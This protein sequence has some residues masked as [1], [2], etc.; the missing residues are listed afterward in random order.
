[1]S[2]FINTNTA[3]ANAAANLST[4]NA[5]L[6]DSLNKLSSGSRIVNAS[7]DAGGLA[8]AM[9]LTSAAL[10]AGASVSSDANQLSFLQAQDG[11][12]QVIGNV[13]TRMSQLSALASDP[14]V[15]TSGYGTEFTQLST[16]LGSL[17]GA[18][19]NG[20]S[21]FGALGNI[22]AVS[23]SFTSGLAIGSAAGITT[24]IG[25]LAS[26]RATNGAQQSSIGYDSQV[27][28]VTQTNLQAAAGQITDVDVATEATNL[29]KWNVMVQYGAAMLAQAN[30]TNQVAL[31]LIQ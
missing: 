19:Y 5:N 27:Q 9:N 22:A 4:S 18:Q 21:I 30:Q 25:D 11:V 6:Q 24:A 20:S 23:T 8:V 12:L 17:A 13:L 7:D 1:M 14:T 28:T 31:K 26:A 2:L 29:A 16:E 10:N 3:A 15:T